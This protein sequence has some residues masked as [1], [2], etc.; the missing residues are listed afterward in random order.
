MPDG[1]TAGNGFR[2]VGTLCSH[3]ARA[4][5]FAL[6]A[7]LQGRSGPDSPEPRESPEPGACERGGASL[8]RPLGQPAHTGQSGLST[9]IVST[10]RPRV[11]LGQVSRT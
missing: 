5:V 6:T 7:A 3:L 8:R 1:R 2:P 4:R 9:R 11:V 10:T